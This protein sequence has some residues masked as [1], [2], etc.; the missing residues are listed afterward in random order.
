MLRPHRKRFILSLLLVSGV[1][2]MVSLGPL[3]PKYVIDVALVRG[4]LKLVLLAGGVFLFTQ[5]F[6]MALWFRAMRLMLWLRESVLF[7]LRAREFGHLQ[8][9]CLRFHHRYPS[10]YLYEQVFGRSIQSVGQVISIL[11][12][13]LAWQSS[14]LV[15][16]LIFCLKLNVPMTGMILLGACGFV[17]ASRK[18]GP[19][20]RSRTA[21]SIR[22]SNR[23]AQYIVDK[24]RGVRTIQAF[25]MEERVESEFRDRMWL[26]QVAGIRAELETIN[27]SFIT[28]GMGYFLTATVVCVGAWLALGS[29]LPV[30]SLVAFIGYQGMLI[31]IIQGLSNV[32]GQFTQARAGWDQLI[33]VMDTQ[34]SVVD[35]P[36]GPMPQNVAG[37]L[38]LRDVHFGYEA[39]KPVLRGI[40]LEIP[41]GQTVALVGRSGGGKTTLANLLMRFYDVD[42]GQILL[43]GTDIRQLPLSGYRAQFGVVL[44]DPYLFDDTIAE[45]LRCA[46]PS[47]REA[48][49]IEAL[50][51][52]SAWDFVSQLPEQLNY[53]V[54]ESGNRLSGGQRQRLAIARCLLMHPGFLILD[55]PTSALD[56]ET[57]QAIQKALGGLF[58]G[59]T[60]LVI[61]HR[62]STIRNADRILVLD[63]GQIVEQ[64]TFAQLMEG[65]GLFWQLQGAPQHAE[66]VS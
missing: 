19:R 12:Q 29:R 23:M 65:R 31:G 46:R 34:S 5:L 26:A 10:G 36:S 24:L 63:Q 60:S 32:Y 51:Q 35:K 66:S 21:E 47:A 15:L 55:E 7:D 28:E 33:A 39:Q 9:M 17:V 2:M 11:F 38:V 27:L 44:Q 42:R 22:Q 58:A 57:E 1:G 53:R 61:A 45:N 49:F 50:R 62:L 6:R 25:G 16:S 54:G 20:I 18:L 37:N 40:D 48:E 52:A 59:R 43:D 13:Q 30:G 3:F 64:G 14:G 56:T 41:Y 4:S 8:R